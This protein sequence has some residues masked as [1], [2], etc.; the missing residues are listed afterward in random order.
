M[1]LNAS[2]GIFFLGFNQG[3]FNVVQLIILELKGVD[4][5]SERSL[6]SALMSSSNPLGGFIGGVLAT[7]VLLC[8]G[9]IKRS[10]FVGDILGII[11]TVIILL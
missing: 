11:G 4:D 3:V 5:D 8:A 10:F 1:C 9:T 2:L 6:Y 7:Y